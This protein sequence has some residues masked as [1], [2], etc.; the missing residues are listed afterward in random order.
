MKNIQ[1]SKIFQAKKMNDLNVMM[2]IIYHQLFCIKPTVQNS[3]L[4]GAKDVIII[5]LVNAKNVNI[6]ISL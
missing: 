6:I 5:F 1:Q 3:K 4:K 2:D